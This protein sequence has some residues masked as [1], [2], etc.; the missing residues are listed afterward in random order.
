MAVNNL[1]D[2]S[3]VSLSDIVGNGKTYVV[4]PYQQDYSWKKDQWEDLWNDILGI[5]DSGS[6]HYMGSIVL[7]NMG[8]KKYHVI[9]GQQR[10]STLI[11][12]VLSVTNYLNKLVKSGIDVEDNKQRIEL[13]Q[14]KFI[15]DKDPAS[16]TY[17]SKL[18]LNENNNSFFQSNLL[19]F[20]SPTNTNTLRDSDKL[21][22]QAY[23]FFVDRLAEAFGEKANGEEVAN[24][25]NKMVAEKLMFIQIVVEDELS[26]YTVFET[27]NSRGVGLTVT[28]L[29]KNYL[30]SIA[31]QVD[32][33]HIK[34]KWKKIINIIGLDNFPVFLRHYWISKNKLIRQEY[35]FRAIKEAIS[36][37]PD[38]IFLLDSLEENAQLYNALSNYADTFWEGDREVK[39]R[40]KELTLFKEIQAYPLLISAYNNLSLE[41]FSKVLKLVSIITFRY[42]VIARLHTNLKEDVYNK[43]AVKVN[44]E[45]MISIQ[46]IAQS[47]KS[48]YPADTDFKNDFST[49]SISTKRGKKI[50]RY[51]LFKIENHLSQNDYDYEENPATIEHILPENGSENYHNDFPPAIHDSVVYRLGNYTLLEDDKNRQCEVLPFDDKK[52]IYQTSQYEMTKQIQANEWTPN[53]IDRRQSRLANCASSI[54]KISQYDSQNK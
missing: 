33:P 19:V 47:V 31:T 32:L 35:L 34:D 18:Q 48:L 5:R 44:N 52:A 2:T 14:R 9:D 46:Q 1:L 30:F 16:L 8:E 6:V 29:L 45:E 54:W 20:R 26:A 22:W 53:T 15:G 12:I 51:I 17:S 4:P 3:T 39:K 28:D 50:V 24:F 13:L 49:K 27:L 42:T 25:L 41:N 40:I 23:N 43:A 38:V 36:S 21:L 7:Q 10:F 11:L 37:S